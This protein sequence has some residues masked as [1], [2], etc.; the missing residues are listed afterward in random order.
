MKPRTAAALVLAAL[1]LVAACATS[2]AEGIR[3]SRTEHSAPT[4]RPAAALTPA[5]ISAADPYLHLAR[6]L[7][8]R[9]VAVWFEADLVKA[10]LAGPAAFDTAMARLGG[11]A[12]ATP[13]AGFKVADELGYDDGITSPAQG[14]AFL[15]AVH[16]AV[17]RVAP[18]AQVLVDMIVPELGCLPW[19]GAAQEACA[20][21]Q[22]DRYP[23]ATQAAVTSYLRAGLVD[24]LDLST[25]LLPA[26]SYAAWGTTTVAAQRVAW[27]HAAAA[28]ASLTTLQARKALAA[29]GGY[30]GD[31]AAARADLETYVDVPVD[32][33]ARAVDIWTWRQ[34]YDGATVSLL[35]PGLSPNPLWSG[36]EARRAA[37]M[38]LLTH[39]TPSQMPTAP[40]A[41]DHECVVAATV[42]DAVFVAAGTG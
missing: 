5:P 29:A 39:M 7:E 16:G 26:S 2:G 33:G 15:Q 20:T 8:Q 35:G 40:A 38:H 32:A 37:G 22:R 36:L 25:G 24:R 42:F 14:L 9:G 6:T 4:A 23:A 19:L 3:Q 34:P 12:Q 30:G 18:D 27:S 28:W 31:A 10:W 13:V 21:A 1:V 17:R 41:F 11:L